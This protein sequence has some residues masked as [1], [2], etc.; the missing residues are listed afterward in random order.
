MGCVFNNYAS[1]LKVKNVIYGLVDPK[2]NEIRYI[3]KAV[4]LENRIRNHFKPSRLLAK[5]HKNN[6]LK[7]LINENKKPFVVVLEKELSENL[8][9]EFEIKW[10]KHY[11][12]IGC[13]L[14]NATDG[15]DGGKLN[16][17]AIDKMKKTKTLNKQQGFWLNKNLSKEHCKN[18]S[19]GKKGYVVSSDTKEKLSKAL[20]NKNTWSKGKKL[21]KETINKMV[22]SR[23]GKP[24]NDREVYQLSLNG[25]VIKLWSNPYE[26]EHYLK[27]S[28]SKVHSVCTGKRKSTGGY[29]WIYKDDYMVQSQNN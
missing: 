27:L 18:I 1:N 11:N 26:A 6:W 23:T 15:G 12:K 13:K 21:S 20:K 16:Q 3:G 19:E 22:I 9:N 4:D 8:L 28:R 14:T 7:L 29:K 24:K 25:D 2:T 17:E 5:T 10:I